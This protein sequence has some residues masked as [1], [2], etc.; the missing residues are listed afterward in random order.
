MG[1]LY[2]DLGV[3][4]DASKADIKKAYKSLAIKCHPDKGGSKEDFIKL[5]EAKR[6]LLDDKQREQ[7]DRTG[8]TQKGPSIEEEARQILSQYFT[9]IIQGDDFKMDLIEKVKTALANDMLRLRQELRNQKDTL[10]KL[11]KHAGRVVSTDEM[12]LFQNII[13]SKI[14]ATKTNI[15]QIESKTRAFD[16]ATLMIDHYSDSKP[17]SPEPQI[18]YGGGFSGG[19]LGGGF[20]TGTS[21][22]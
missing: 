18:T 3:A 15:E 13:T 2:E 21:G 7:Y 1:N 22:I 11:T 14:E 8:S 20:F 17:E 5:E 10:D 6:I 19:S 16:Q 12:N 9:G 4:K